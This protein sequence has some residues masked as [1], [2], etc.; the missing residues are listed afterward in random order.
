MIKRVFDLLASSVGIVVLLPVFF[1]IGLLIKINSPGPVLFR[2]ERIGKH[3]RPFWLY[4]FRT[5]VPGAE[6]GGSI[7]VG[8]DARITR[9]GHF[10]RR[11]KIDEFP[12]LVNVIKGEM[13]LVGPRPE[14]RRY[15]EM[16]RSDFEEVLSVR[17]GITDLASI[18][19]RNE[20]VMLGQAKDP[21]LLYASR[22]LPD[23]IRLAKAYLRQASFLTDLL[24]IAK[25]LFGRR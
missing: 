7:T 2:Q 18:K 22:I 13:S 11:V 19:Y 21:E 10:L 15:V 14:V 6:F 17:P 23:K 5:M 12:Q 9:V 24:I 20:A 1:V 4:K 8:K 16:F 3:F 25:T